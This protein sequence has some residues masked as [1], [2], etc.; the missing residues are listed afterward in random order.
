MVFVCVFVS[1]VHL[2]TL[3]LYIFNAFCI[4]IQAVGTCQ[5][6]QLGCLRLYKV[7]HGACLESS[8]QDLTRKNFSL[9]KQH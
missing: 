9:Y 1:F 6:R 7:G 5:R 8:W 3:L 4:C 2:P